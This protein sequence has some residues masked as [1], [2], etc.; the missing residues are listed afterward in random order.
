V[1]TCERVYV[2]ECVR[3]SVSEARIS[4]RIVICLVVRHLNHHSATTTNKH[5]YTPLAK[6][7]TSMCAARKESGF[8][9][10]VSDAQV[11]TE[12]AVEKRK[13]VVVR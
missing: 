10:C 4:R 11:L 9:V 8:Y 2:S 13:E 7:S 12:Q 1:S 3:V 5:Q 6:K